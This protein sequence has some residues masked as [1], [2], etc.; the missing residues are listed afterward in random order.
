[1][2]VMILY[3]NSFDKIGGVET[4]LYYISEELSQ[5]GHEVILLSQKSMKDEHNED[6]TDIAKIIRYSRPTI[7]KVLLP[8]A[9]F[10]VKNTIGSQISD[11]IF[12]ENPDLIISRDNLLTVVAKEKAHNC[13]L[14]YIPPVIIKLYNQ[15]IRKSFTLKE[16][17]ISIIRNL[18][19]KIE[20]EYQKEAF[21]YANRIIVFSNN[22][23]SQ[24]MDIYNGRYINKLSVLYP[25]VGEKFTYTCK[26]TYEIYDEFNIIYTQ[27]IILFVGRIVQEKNLHMLI[28]AFK[29]VQGSAVLVIV[30]DGSA[31]DSLK[32]LVNDMGINDKVYFAGR[33]RDVER[34]YKSATISV[35]PSTYEAF[36]NV[37]P[38]SLS[39]GTPVIAFKNNPPIVRN[40]VEELIT[41][42]ENGFIVKEF[43]ELSLKESIEEA[44]E[45]ST[46][47]DYLMM[48]KNCRKYAEEN[49][50][51]KVFIRN[52]LLN[53]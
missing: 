36:G 51:W 22:V 20:G 34:F 1:M 24:V 16:L 7:P 50:D 23:K 15:K 5:L 31:L 4:T 19:L 32:K 27:K 41:N 13:N 25:G 3:R 40:A 6:I 17:I 43:S 11:I 8:L 38:E 39:C 18:Q 48:R 14:I 10:I 28:K 2:K 52:L 35:I 44:L 21:K 47:E 26:P 37:I 53:I 29:A 33:R 30:G 42:G 45:F 12:N 9:P 46:L 49:F